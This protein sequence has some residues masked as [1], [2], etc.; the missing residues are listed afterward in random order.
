[1]LAK[2]KYFKNSMQK[3]VGEIGKFE[4]KTGGGFENFKNFMKKFGGKIGKLEKFNG[5]TRWRNWKIFKYITKKQVAKL[6]NL[7][8]MV[9]NF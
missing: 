1:M 3:Q 7:K 8:N 2:L 5:K 4:Q 6:E 9:A